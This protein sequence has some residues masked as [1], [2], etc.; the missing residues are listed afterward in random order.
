MVSYS[1][2]NLLVYV[3]V[4]CP[5]YREFLSDRRQR[6]VVDGAASECMDPN[7]FRYATWKC[8]GSS[9]VYLIYQRNV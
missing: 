5:F 2:R 7:R 8:V 3:A 4:C 1:N 6:V 9:S